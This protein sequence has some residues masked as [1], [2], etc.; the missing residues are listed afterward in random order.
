MFVNKLLQ[1]CI[2]DTFII[3]LNFSQTLDKL[4]TKKRRTRSYLLLFHRLLFFDLST[5]NISIFWS[6]ISW[7]QQ[8][9]PINNW[10]ECIFC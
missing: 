4:N 7:K 1:H 9:E 10:D 3:V 5:K 6:N 2:F 8:W